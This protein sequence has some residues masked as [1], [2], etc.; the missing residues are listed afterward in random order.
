MM[1]KKNSLHKPKILQTQT[2]ESSLA[3]YG[4]RGNDADHFSKELFQ[5][6]PFVISHGDFYPIADF[7]SKIAKQIQN[8]AIISSRKDPDFGGSWQNP[9]KSVSTYFQSQFMK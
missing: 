6:T 7:G 3:V 9:L 5:P 8:Y 4:G 1:M 2:G